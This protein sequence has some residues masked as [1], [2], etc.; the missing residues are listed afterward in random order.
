ML[1]RLLLIHQNFPGQFRQLSPYLQSRGHDLTAIGSHDRPLPFNCR[2][3]RYEAPPAP[4]GPVHFGSHLWHEGL[5]RA[6]AVARLCDALNREGWRPDRI[7]GHCGWGETLGIH[8]VW[9]DVPQILWPELW[10]LPEHGGYGFDPDKPLPNLSNRI[11]QLGRNALTRAALAHAESWVLPTHHQAKSFPSEFQGSRLHV[12]HEGIDTNVA[13]PNSNVTLVGHDFNL[14]R[15]IPTLTII[16]RNLER[17]RGFDVFMRALP[18]VLS[19]IKNLRVLIVGG[20]ELGY[21]GG[22]PAAEPLRKRMLEELDGQL[23]LNRIH[24]LGRV[25]YEHFLS[26]MQLSWVHVYLSYPFILSWSLLEAMSCGCAI[27][28][29]KGMPVEEV[30]DNGVEGLLIEHNRPEILAKTIIGLMTKPDL[31]LRLGKAARQKALHFDQTIT[32]PKLAQLIEA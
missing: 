9:P 3:L 22:D 11:E 7:L 12:I 2:L 15:S 32:L 17:L 23:D 1:L 25:P 13:S 4:K 27:I 10:V 29:S 5:R 20:D 14:N 21:G 19:Q 30:I 28:G 16:N 8:E 24:F 26:V 31:R 18:E 6:E